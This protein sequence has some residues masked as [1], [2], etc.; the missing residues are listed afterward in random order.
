MF[1]ILKNIYIFG[2]TLKQTAM[3]KIKEAS[4]LLDVDFLDH[5]IL[6]EETYYSMADNAD[7]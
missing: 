2:E 5:I 1:C 4:K 7:F 3:K 6:T